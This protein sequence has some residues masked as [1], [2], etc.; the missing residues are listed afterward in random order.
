MNAA[1]VTISFF[2]GEKPP[3]RIEVSILPAEV[4]PNSAQILE[5]Y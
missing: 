4:V 5:G 3:L 1:V 2:I